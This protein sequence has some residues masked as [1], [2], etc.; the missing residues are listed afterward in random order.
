VSAGLA[1]PA[2]IRDPAAALSIALLVIAVVVAVVVV[3][4]VAERA[5][6]E[7]AHARIAARAEPLRPLLLALAAAEDDE[8]I[9]AVAPFVAL[10]ETTWRAVAPSMI[11]LLPKLRGDT[12]AAVVSV[13]TARGVLAKAEADTYHRSPLRRAKAA[14]LL[15]V[16]GVPFAVPRLMQLL[17]DADAE[18][19]VVAARGLGHIGDPVAADAL[20]TCLVGRRG[21]PARVAGDAVLRIGVPAHPAVVRA[22]AAAEP[23]RR[24]IAADIAGLIGAVSAAPDLAR[25]VAADPE[26]LLRPRAARALGRLGLPSSGLVLRQALAAADEAL[27]IAAAEGLGGLGDRA[28]IDALLGVAGR[29]S[30]LV[31]RAACRSLAEHG[32][33]GRAALRFLAEQDHAIAGEVLRMLDLRLAGRTRRDGS[34]VSAGRS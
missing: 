2:L 31:S 18:V 27:V 10:D 23:V 22:L 25:M 28:S 15:G 11:T 16:A 4:T 26:P 3:V 17:G 33:P 20:M 1:W 5:R 13:L 34:L 8:V 30:Y 29:T 32:E 14:R 24:G 21:L 7:A 6:R 19:R 12:H 9:A